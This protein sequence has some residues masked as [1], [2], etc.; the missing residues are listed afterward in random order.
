MK[1]M[2]WRGFESMRLTYDEEEK[3]RG[4]EIELEKLHKRIKIIMV[5]RI[6]M[7]IFVVLALVSAYLM[8]LK[9]IPNY[10]FFICILFTGIFGMFG[11]LKTGRG[12]S[13]PVFEDLNIKTTK[14]RIK[15]I[16]EQIQ[17]IKKFACR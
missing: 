13:P 11:G 7:F 5:M 6:I 17:A 4:L 12:N 1:Q 2:R 10:W 15:K 3:M 9:K 8:R 14:K 16:K